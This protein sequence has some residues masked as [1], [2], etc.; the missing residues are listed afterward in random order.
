VLSF[1]F[2]LRGMA[3]IVAQGQFQNQELAS[4]GNPQ[5]GLTNNCMF[6]YKFG[7]RMNQKTVDMQIRTV[8]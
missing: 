8:L 6:I 7:L 2:G 3:V 1:L 5:I 4:P